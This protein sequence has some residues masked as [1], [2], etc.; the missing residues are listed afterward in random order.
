M[1]KTTRCWFSGMVEKGWH[2]KRYLVS[3][4]YF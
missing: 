3:I 2:A 4:W 1:G